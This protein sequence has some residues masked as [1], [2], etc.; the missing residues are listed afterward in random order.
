[1]DTTAELMDEAT[2]DFR[3][4]DDALIKH[5]SL[6]HYVEDRITMLKEMG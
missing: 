6:K 5:D 4:E 2:N 1:M 3:W